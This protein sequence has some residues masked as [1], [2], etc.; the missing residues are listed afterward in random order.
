MIIPNSK[1]SHQLGG[2]KNELVELCEIF[3]F[4]SNFFREALQPIT[5]W[6][7]IYCMA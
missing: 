1:N 5:D 7:L 4:L 2:V 3:C 6:Y